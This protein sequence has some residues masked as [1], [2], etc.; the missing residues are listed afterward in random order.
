MQ[1]TYLALAAVV[2]A[3]FASPTLQQFAQTSAE[4]DQVIT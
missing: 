2:G 1:N 3:A 4:S